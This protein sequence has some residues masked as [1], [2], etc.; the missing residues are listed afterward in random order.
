MRSRAAVSKSI[1]AI[2]KAASPMIFTASFFRCSHFCPHDQAK[3]IAQ[4]RGLT[5]TD[6][7]VRGNRFVEGE[8]LI[9]RISL[10]HA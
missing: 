2:P 9:A 6:V 1:P 10:N 7:T 4:L 5:P 8:G 3:S